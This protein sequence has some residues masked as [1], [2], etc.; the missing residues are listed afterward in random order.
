[1]KDVDI[2][3]R[4]IIR[5]PYF[6]PDTKDIKS[7]FQ[8]MRIKKIHLSMV[9]D[10]YGD[11][12][13]IITLEDIIEEILGEIRDEHEGFY[14]DIREIKKDVYIANGKLD[15]DEMKRVVGIDIEKGDFETLGGFLI[16]K[17]GRIPQVDEKIE[18]QGILFF[19]EDS[20]ERM[21]KRI[22]I[23]RLKDNVQG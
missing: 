18:V 15:F 14:P 20:D 17:F 22:R 19:I 11:I 8:E 6:L 3:L 7:T 9:F 10:E 16:E 12:A 2:S 1:L 4:T 21:V 13:G 23:E 5:Q